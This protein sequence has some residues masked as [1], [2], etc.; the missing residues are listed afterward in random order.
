MKVLAGLLALASCA[1]EPLDVSDTAARGEGKPSVREV[2]VL[3]LDER[4]GDRI[5]LIE[6]LAIGKQTDDSRTLFFRARD[7]VVDM[8]G[9]IYVLYAGNARVQVFDTEGR[10]VRTFGAQ[11]QGPGELQGAEPRR[12]LY[13]WA[14]KC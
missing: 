3:A 11:G 6:D 7:V 13:L 5:G 12:R 9:R 10:Y 1:G 2:S 4:G 14:R 8:E